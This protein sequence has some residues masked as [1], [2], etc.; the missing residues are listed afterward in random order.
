MFKIQ[1]ATSFQWPV[2]VNVPRDGGGFATHEFTAEYKMLEQSKI[3]LA[4]EKFKNEDSDMLKEIVIGWN[5]VQD[6][7]GNV[8]PY[9]DENRDTLL[10]IPYVRTA[11]MKGFFEAVSG[12][13]VKKGN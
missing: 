10:E 8:L 4:L 11:L 6:S 5:G 3:D 7:D 13:K 12:N 2:Q 1:K 9:S